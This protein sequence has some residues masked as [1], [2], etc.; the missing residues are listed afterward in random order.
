MMNCRAIMFSTAGVV[1]APGYLRIVLRK[2]LF[3]R[4]SNAP[5]QTD[6]LFPDSKQTH[7]P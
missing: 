1:S 5:L 2:S 3:V 7:C 4:A 6:R